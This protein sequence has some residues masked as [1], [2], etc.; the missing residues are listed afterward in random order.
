MKHLDDKRLFLDMQEH[1]ERYSDEQLEAMMAEL[2]K[3]PDAEEAWR[4]FKPTSYYMLRKIAAIFLA[5]AFL[6]VLSFAGYRALSDWHGTAKSPVEADT[7]AVK[8]ERF[9]F[10]VQEGD[11]IFRFEN[12]RL[13]SILAVVSRHYGRQ[14]VFRDKASQHL[15]LYMTCHTTQSL[16]EFVEMLNEFE[17]FKLSQRFDILFVDSDEKKEGMR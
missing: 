17:G 4:H 1:P 16:D 12:I 9:Y 3:E 8:T 2:D 5:V 11:T 15:R 10:D 14:V 6:G 7:L 13:D